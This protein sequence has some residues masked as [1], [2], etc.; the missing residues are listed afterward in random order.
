MSYPLAV[1]GLRE[2]C[3]IYLCKTNWWP[4]GIYRGLYLYIIC[5]IRNRFLDAQYILFGIK[6]ILVPEYLY[7]GLYPGN[8]GWL[9]G[10]L[11]GWLFGWWVGGLVGDTFWDST[12]F[13]LIFSGLLP[14][15]LD[16]LRFYLFPTPPLSHCE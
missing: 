16:F 15:S 5:I 14:I 10:W 1:K 9:V 11:V 7:S 3:Q 6:M 13:P 8:D 4:S 12:Q 2:I